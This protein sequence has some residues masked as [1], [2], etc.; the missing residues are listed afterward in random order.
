[1]TNSVERSLVIAKPDAV[2]RGLLGEI[3]GRFEKRGLKIIAAKFIQVSKEF[4]AEHYSMHIGKSFYDGLVSYITSSPVLAMVWEG[5][6]AVAA[7]RQTIGSTNPLEALPGSIRHDLS[8]QTSRNLIHASDSTEN[9]NSEIKLWFKS[10]ELYSWS[11]TN[12]Q[13]I[14][15]KN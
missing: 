11:L 8:L 7:I 12:D 2:Q 3:I 10:E 14:N 4:A 5:E 1:M 6:N 15:G 9:A 13:W